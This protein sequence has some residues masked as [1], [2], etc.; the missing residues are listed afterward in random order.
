MCWLFFA[1]HSQFSSKEFLYHSVQIQLTEGIQLKCLLKLTLWSQTKLPGRI[2]SKSFLVPTHKQ[3]ENIIKSSS[4]TLTLSNVCIPH[5]T[6]LPWV[7][8]Y[9]IYCIVLLTCIP[10]VPSVNLNMSRKEKSPLIWYFVNFDELFCSNDHQSWRG[11]M[12]TAWHVPSHLSIS[13]LLTTLPWCKTW[14]LEAFFSCFSS[15]GMVQSSISESY[16]FVDMELTITK[17]LLHTAA[18]RLSARVRC[19]Y[20][21]TPLYGNHHSISK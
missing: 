13:W 11:R 15:P 6:E 21:K 9:W 16:L 4:L 3:Q 10:H 20:M 7:P 19:I 8:W 1:L 12:I 14:A 18:P 5:S 17:D 2:F